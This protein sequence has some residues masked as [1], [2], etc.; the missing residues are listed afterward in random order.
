MFDPG[1]T[2]PDLKV[3]VPL[4]PTGARMNRPI[5]TTAAMAALCG[6]A[7]LAAMPLAGGEA[8]AAPAAGV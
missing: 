3:R 5:L 1:A 2:L 4:R 6:V 8:A 7:L